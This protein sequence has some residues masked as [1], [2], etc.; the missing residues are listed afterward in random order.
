M[1]ESHLDVGA[2]LKFRA[3]GPYTKK[4][5]QTERSIVMIVCLEPGQVIPAHSHVSREAFVYGLQGAVRLTPGDGPA[6]IRPGELRFYDGT[7]SISPRNVGDERAAF[8]VTLVR[9]KHA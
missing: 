8:L 5:I 6:E 9:K 7:S 3:E 2:E 4:L 1:D